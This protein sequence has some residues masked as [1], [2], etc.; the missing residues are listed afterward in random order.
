M[1]NMHVSGPAEPPEEET[2]A[3]F[4]KGARCTVELGWRGARTQYFT[5]TKTTTTT[6]YEKS[7]ERTFHWQV[8]G[9]GVW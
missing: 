8:T 4:R 5:T 3:R 6:T 2:H 7:I 1:Y 9:H